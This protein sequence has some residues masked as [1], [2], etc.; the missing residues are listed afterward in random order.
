ML[1]SHRRIHCLEMFESSYAYLHQLYVFN[2][3]ACQTSSKQHPS[4]KVDKE[5]SFSLRSNHP[6]L[7]TLAWFVSSVFLYNVRFVTP[8]SDAIWAFQIANPCF[9][10][11][12]GNTASILGLFQDAA[13]THC[14]FFG[15][16]HGRPNSMAGGF[17]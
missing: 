14:R 3:F 15:L 8:I 5:G 12:S 17:H 16:L 13:G 2:C 10:L 6:H 1:R 11:E 4:P 7:L 9:F